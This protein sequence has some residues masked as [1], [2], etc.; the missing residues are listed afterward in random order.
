[1]KN[2]LILLLILFG[3]SNV[4]AQKLIGVNAGKTVSLSFPAPV[5]YVD[6]GSAF[7]DAKLV[8]P[9]SKVVLIKALEQ[10]FEATN[11]TV[12]TSDDA[13]F[14]FQ[15]QYDPDPVTYHME[16][17]AKGATAASYAAG[18]MDN[19]R[20]AVGMM[21][22]REGLFA[23]VQGIYVLDS[24]LFF[25]LKVAN[26]TALSYDIA[27]IRFLIVNKKSRKQVASQRRPVPIQHLEGAYD[28]VPQMGTAVIVAVLPKIALS[29]D[30]RLHIE[31]V[32]QEGSRNLRLHIPPRKLAGAIRLPA[33]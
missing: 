4:K 21:H 24:L 3:S 18:I 10:N 12:V 11:L 6:L 26:N 7:I 25:H 13:V 33:R 9:G 2:L 28:R 30:H 1:M 15:V 22:G 31:L 29:H 32:E 14:S 27:T 5:S 20:R 8:G 23:Q 19:G 16:I 17:P